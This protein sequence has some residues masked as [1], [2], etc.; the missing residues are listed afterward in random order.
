MNTLRATC[1]AI[2]TTLVHA[3]AHA[4]VSLSP[5][6]VTAGSSNQIV[7][8]PL[9]LAGSGFSID[10]FGCRLTYPTSL[11]NFQSISATASLTQGWFIVSGAETTPGVVEI[12][13]FHT[14]PVT[15]S[16]VLV[17][18][19]FQVKSNVLGSGAIAL[20]NFVDDVTGATTSN[21][22]FQ[23]AVSPGA[24]GLL[25]QYYDGLDFTG[26]L[27]QRV[28]P[29]VSFNW[30]AGAPDPSMGVNDYSVR[31]TGWV[32]PDFTQTFTFYTQTDD[33]V[34]LWVNNQL[35]INRWTDQASTEWS[36]TIALTAGTLVPIRMEYYERG[37]DAVARLSW[38]SASQAKQVIPGERMLAAS[39]AQGVGDVD[40]NGIIAPSDVACAF[41]IYL[42]NQGLAVGCNYQSY[43]C[44]VTSSD[45]NCSGAVTPSDALAIEQRRA[46]GLPPSGCF[47][48]PAPPAPVPPLSLALTQAVFNESGTPRLRVTIS[49]QDGTGL[50]AFG[51]RL[52][53]PTAQL[54][55]QR[56][57]AGNVTS[58]WFDVD[59]RV[60]VS[61]QALVGGFDPFAPAW[62]GP[63]EVCHVYFNF[64]GAPGPV[65]GLSLTGLVDDFAGASVGATVT[66]ASPARPGFR[67]GANHPNPFN[68]A[69][70]IPYHVGATERV[71]LAVYDV[72]GARVRALVEGVRAAGAYEAV[73]DGRDDGGRVVASGVYFCVMQAGGFRATQRMVLLK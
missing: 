72:R 28:D 17:Y 23:A 68:P 61:G 41:S 42:E 58:E 70:R 71:T 40:G 69:T 32:Q 38:S 26:T 3:N 4:A 56:V 22:V 29:V 52:L 36:G 45:V 37:G 19:V 59:A 5:A 35:I 50:D 24:A 18:A 44:E 9:T 15:A 33:G 55:F 8:I 65:A 30:G 53:F 73:W 49:V 66:G 2:L 48:S 47:A 39:C 64:V 43:A 14:T 20:S 46:S 31:W 54:A 27:L 13:G 12:G 67:L 34:R 60:P 51:A 11:L 62:S 16:G 25:G 1:V 21:G 57:E 63:G 7:F 10:A 6:P